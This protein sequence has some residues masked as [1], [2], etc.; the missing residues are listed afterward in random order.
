MRR[1]FE[2]LESNEWNIIVL[3]EW[4]VYEEILD[5]AMILVGSKPYKLAVVDTEWLG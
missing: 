2:F 1:D 3:V 5:K 4:R